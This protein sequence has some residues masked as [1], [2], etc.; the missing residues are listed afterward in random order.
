LLP[1]QRRKQRAGNSDLRAWSTQIRGEKG[2]KKEEKNKSER[3]F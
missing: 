3:D 2:K 1:T